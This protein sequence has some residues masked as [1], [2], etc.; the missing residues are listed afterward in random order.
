MS[1]K[2][3]STFQLGIILAT[4]AVVSCT[5]LAL[6]NNFTSPVIKQN[7][8]NKANE[9]MKIVF[10]SADSFQEVTDFTPSTD[11]TITIQ[12]MYLAKKDGNVI[13]CVA[14]VEGPT[15]DRATIIVGVDLSG[16]VTGLQFLKISDSP[17]FGLKANDPTF[18]VASG[19]TFYGQFEGLKVADGF[20]SNST[21]DVISGATIT[22]NGVADLVT[23]GTYSA[24]QYLKNFG[25][26]EVSLS[27]PQSGE[28]KKL[29]SYDEAVSDIM[30]QE[31]QKTD[32]DYS[33]NKV[34][35]NI[36]VTKTS[37]ISLDGHVTAYTAE[38]RGQTYGDAGGAVMV[39]V[40]TD[41][42][43]LGARITSLSDSPSY[44]MNA[45]KP[46]F[47]NQFTGMS[48]R[49]N[50]LSSSY[51]AV[52]GASITSDCI[53][54]MVKVASYVCLTYIDQDEEDNFILNEHY[55]EE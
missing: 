45:A 1:K 54:D 48:A 18:H 52:T 36:V 38:V 13:G 27:A 37:Q 17:G 12:N 14:Q 29:F 10:S 35:H 44:G 8:I 2:I 47:Y 21:F 9:S 5:V 22:S 3:Y 28:E 11:S 51:D 25:G 33:G 50:I 26:Q 7:Q 19:K 34:I 6:V 53:A 42:N 30:G 55:L 24:M 43:I 39:A 49:D 20:K 16:T 40:D 46:S 41:G 31:A 23:Q 15:Y 32:I 4:Y